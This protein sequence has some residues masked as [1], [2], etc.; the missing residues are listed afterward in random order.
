MNIL[1]RSFPH[2][3]L[4]PF[5]DD[6]LPNEFFL[7][8]KIQPDAEVFY[9]HHEFVHE[10]ET[11]H[12]LTGSGKAH[13][14]IHVE[15]KRNYFRKVFL[16]K[17]ARGG[18]SISAS[19]L[20]GHVEMVGLV[21]SAGSIADYAPSGMHPDYEGRGFSLD[22][23]DVLA[24]SQTQSFEAYTDYDPLA[25]ISSIMTVRQSEDLDE[26]PMAVDLE[27]D[28]ITV[29]LSKTDFTRYTD[30]KADPS[31]GP[32]LANQVVVPA[33]LEALHEMR[34]LPDEEFELDMQKRWFRSVH[35]K[36][37]DLGIDIRARDKPVMEVLQ[38]LLKLP[39]RRS[40]EGLIRVNPLE[41]GE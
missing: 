23:G 9:I 41:E 20:V 19:D 34:G 13:Y 32:L 25:R 14:A 24:A 17:E 16:L 38:L 8:L 10:N 1:D 18:I 12:G 29:V 33:L 4:S 37:S 28:K 15:C 39:L 22:V 3:V 36:I 2:P 11:I 30:L 35:K 26:G 6:V 21:V 7:K 5:R 40:L 31:L 27:D